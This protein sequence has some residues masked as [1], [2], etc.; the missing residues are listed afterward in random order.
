[1][2]TIKEEVKKKITQVKVFSLIETPS[3]E[4]MLNGFL[5]NNKIVNISTNVHDGHVSAV[6]IYS[7]E[8]TDIVEKQVEEIKEVEILED[9]E[10]PKGLEIKKGG[11]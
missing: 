9:I 2:K 4:A 1:M 6:I 5:R 8:I 3:G 10:F 11:I 7:E